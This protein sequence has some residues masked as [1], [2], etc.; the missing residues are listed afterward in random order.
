MKVTIDGISIDV[1]PGTSILNAARQI[2]GDIVREAPKRGSQLSRWFTLVSCK[3]VKTQ[4]ALAR[5]TVVLDHLSGGRV[6]S[7][8]GSSWSV[9]NREASRRTDSATYSSA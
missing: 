7:G 9:H 1:E 8:A 4:E 2:G 5:E 3:W 6:G